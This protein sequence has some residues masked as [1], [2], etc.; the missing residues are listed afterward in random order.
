MDNTSA[1]IS[2]FKGQE[3]KKKLLECLDKEAR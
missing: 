2:D 1:L 3:L